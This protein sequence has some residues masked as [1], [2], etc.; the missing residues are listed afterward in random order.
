MELLEFS[1]RV[2]IATLAGLLIG[3]E[4]ELSRK[5]AGLKTNALVALGSCIFILL[6]L[7]FRGEENVDITRVLGQIVSGIG[8]IGAGTILHYKTS[9]RGLNTAATI[10]CSAGTG[11]LAALAMYQE[12]IVVSAIIIVVNLVLGIFERKVLHKDIDSPER[13]ID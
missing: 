13:N 3:A 2:G 4:R 10:W 12:L 5:N 7:N 9:V 11:C 6:S 1:T 8:F